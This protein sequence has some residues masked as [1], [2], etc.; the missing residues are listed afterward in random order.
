MIKVYTAPSCSSCRKVKKYFDEFHI[1]YVEKNILATPLT[2]DDIFKMLYN[3]E[4]GFE[5]IISTRSKIMKERNINL[6]NMNMN[7]VIEFIIAN[8]TVLKRPIIVDKDDLQVGYNTDDISLFLPL[9]LRNLDCDIC[10]DGNVEIKFDNNLKEEL[11][12]IKD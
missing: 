10:E 9:E 6:D 7:E 1:E 8:P 2:K 3:S 5:D 12:K 4:N 11:K